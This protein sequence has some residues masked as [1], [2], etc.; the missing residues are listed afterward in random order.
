MAIGVFAG[1]VS[2]SSHL[3]G[4]IT[5]STGGEGA[6]YIVEG[7]AQRYIDVPV[8]YACGMSKGFG[9]SQMV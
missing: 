3:T 4:K 1:S 6:V 8:V 9:F 2:M 5:T 7:I